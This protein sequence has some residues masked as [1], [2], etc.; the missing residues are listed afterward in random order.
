LISGSILTI[1]RFNDIGVKLLLILNFKL[2]TFKYKTFRIFAINSVT[3]TFEL[4][5][6]EFLMEEI[7]EHKKEILS[8]SKLSPLEI[9]KAL[10]LLQ[11][12]IKFISPSA[13]SEFLEEAKKISPPDDFPY[14]ALALKI[15]SLGLKVAIWSNDR[16]LKEA[17][18][19]KI[20]VFTTNEIFEILRGK[21]ST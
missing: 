13:F 6:P 7:E 2:T 14:V 18:K 17:L 3:E 20:D 16:E 5:A 8:K 12:E 10:K 9:E 4:L 15:K 1:S 21:S 11:R 19:N